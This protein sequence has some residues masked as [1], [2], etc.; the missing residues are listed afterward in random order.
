MLID[1]GEAIE[2]AAANGK[3]LEL[4]AYPS[5]L[6]LGDEDVRRAVDSRVNVAIDTDAHSLFE[7]DFMEYGVH[8]AR[9][10]WAP[11]HRVLNVLTYDG[12]LRFLNGRL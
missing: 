2:A 3:V 9:R 1:M 11:R 7:L 12:L 4:N 5:R 10:G 6:D 8:T